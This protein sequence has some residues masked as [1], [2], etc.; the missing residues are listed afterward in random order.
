MT[1]KVLV[2]VQEITNIRKHINADKLVVATVQGYEVIIN[3]QA[4]GESMETFSQLKGRKGVMFYIDSV[5]PDEHRKLEI[6]SYL[7]NGRVRTVKLRK[8]YSQ[9]LFLSFD[10]VA[11]L[12][13][14]DLDATVNTDLTSQFN[15]V[16][17]YE[18]TDKERPNKSSPS[19]CQ[20]FPQWFPKTDQ[21][22]LQEQ[23]GLLTNFNDR[24]FV[25]TVKIDGM[26]STYY[27]NPDEKEGGICSRNYRLTEST[28]PKEKPDPHFANIEQK[29]SILE[30]LKIQGR[31]L[32]IQGEIYGLGINSNRMK[33]NNVDFAVFDIYEWNEN[34]SGKYLPYEDVVKLCQLLSLP[35]VPFVCYFDHLMANVSEWVQLAEKQ[36]YDQIS[37]VKGLPAEGVV[38][39]TCDNSTP[40]M[41]FKVIS[42][43]YLEKYKL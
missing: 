4:F 23:V 6:F 8:E 1:D 27:Y 39:K 36:V 31:R 35:I 21:P 40:Y 18:Q 34:G 37:S 33:T 13:K 26:S 30:K 14:I 41:S 5:I 20:P 42:R 38:V 10:S 28:V 24:R 43:L 16:K 9:G 15:V 32:A 22:R 25:A 2:S 17:Y 29:Y 19:F 7:E 3:P 11:P 12:V